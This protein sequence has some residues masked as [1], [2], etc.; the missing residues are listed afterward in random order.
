M[1][2]SLLSQHFVPAS[3]RP[4]WTVAS[5]TNLPLLVVQHGWGAEP[6]VAKVDVKV[7]IPFRMLHFREAVAATFI[8]MG[9]YER[10]HATEQS[11]GYTDM[12]AYCKCFLWQIWICRSGSSWMRLWTGMLTFYAPDL[13]ARYI[14]Y[15]LLLQ[16]FC[17]IINCFHPI[18]EQNSG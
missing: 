6:E 4:K 18:R 17:L 12:I 7:Q 11:G 16:L 9:W 2:G 14:H 1:S 3:L 13:V 8:A 15:R 5:L 10:E